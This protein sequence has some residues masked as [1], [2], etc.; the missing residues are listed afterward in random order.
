MVGMPADR[1]RLIVAVL[2]ARGVLL[3]LGL[4]A[5]TVAFVELVDVKLSLAHVAPWWYLGLIGIAAVLLALGSPR[6]ARLPGD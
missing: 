5:T 4:V 1:S 2:V 6:R 3:V